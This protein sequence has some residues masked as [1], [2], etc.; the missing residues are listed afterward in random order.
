[1]PSNVQITAALV[2]AGSVPD[3]QNCIT[4][5]NAL[6]PTIAAYMGVAATDPE[7][8][9]SQT[10]STAE[11]ALNA[12]NNALAQVAALQGSIPARRTS[13]ANLVP[14]SGSGDKDIVISW[15]PAMPNTNYGVYITLHGPAAATT[16][17]IFIVADGS[18]TTTSVN[19]R[20]LNIPAGTWS[21][22]WEVEAL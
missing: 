14:I 17:P 1:M 3:D 7:Q 19:G 18:R 2:V 10:D 8:P 21:Y 13:G 11:L 22:S 20:M 4:D 9:Q 6:L 5:V 15:L 12:A 16:A